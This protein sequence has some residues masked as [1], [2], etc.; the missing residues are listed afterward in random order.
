MIFA[1]GARKHKHVEVTIMICVM[2]VMQSSKQPV[3]FQKSQTYL[4]KYF[5]SWRISA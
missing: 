2:Q 5:L 4:L 1:N 3:D